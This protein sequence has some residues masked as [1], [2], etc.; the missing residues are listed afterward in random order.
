MTFSGGEP[1]L[2]KYVLLEIL[3]RLDKNIHKMLFT[4][5]DINELDEYQK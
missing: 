4:G 3:K 1:L 2:Q 5:Y